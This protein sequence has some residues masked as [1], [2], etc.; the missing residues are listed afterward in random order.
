MN[1]ENQERTGRGLINLLLIIIVIG[2]A[3][4]LLWK[5]GT[6]SSNESEEIVAELAI[7]EELGIQSP[8]QCAVTKEQWNALNEEVKQLRNELTQLRNE[9]SQVKKSSVTPAKQTT[10]TT[11]KPTKQTSSSTSVNGNDVTLAN[12]SHDWVNTEA[13]VALKNNTSNT[14]TSVTGRMIYLDMSGNMLDYQDFTKS[15]KI[16][17]GF[18]KS[19]ELLGYGYNDSYAYYKSEVRGS[20][21]N[22]KY[23]VQFQLKSYKIQK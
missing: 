3:V 4:L 16:E 12:Y 2:V 19:F 6:F 18:V 22:R 17:P 10:Q 8:E 11:T 1:D 7:E 15:V 5:F 20:M 23:K 9:L 14:I 21:A 13:T